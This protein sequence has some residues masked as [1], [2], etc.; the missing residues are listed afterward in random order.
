MNNLQNNQKSD[1]ATMGY[2]TVLAHVVNGIKSGMPI[3]KTLSKL[4]YNRNKFYAQCDEKTKRYL[5]ELK[6]LKSVDRT[7][8]KYSKD[9]NDP[10]VDF[11]VC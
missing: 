10:F 8:H 11:N 6:C 3:S 1:T 9:R 5:N 4:K 2:D 7:N